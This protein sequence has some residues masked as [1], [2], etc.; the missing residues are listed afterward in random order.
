MIRGSGVVGNN[1]GS[2]TNELER[3]EAVGMAAAEGLHCLSLAA[4]GGSETVQGAFCW[5]SSSFVPAFNGAGLFAESLFSPSTIAGIDAYFRERGRPYSLVTIDGVADAARNGL[6]GLGYYEFDASPAMLLEGEPQRWHADL[7]QLEICT[8]STPGDLRLFRAVISRVF[9]ISP[10]EVDLI[11]ND[12]VLSTPVVR[13]Y[14]GF[15]QGTPVAGASLVVSGALAGI[16]NVGTL[17]DYRRRGISAEIMHHLVAEAAA[18]GYGATM[19]LASPDGLP[20][21]RRL[22]YTT[23]STVRMYAPLRQP[24]YDA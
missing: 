4:G 21:Y 19:L 13:H 14:L 8:V 18:L 11:L 5:H 3:L 23:V 2:W 10:L 22:G 7:P 6:S 24:G 15:W 16:W 1:I 17:A 9:Y 20:L 12:G